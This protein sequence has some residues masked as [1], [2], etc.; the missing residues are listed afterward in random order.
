MSYVGTKDTY[1]EAVSEIDRL[2]RE[3]EEERKKQWLK[4]DRF[5]FTFIPV[6]DA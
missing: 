4:S 6:G 2:A 5:T 3:H 1:A